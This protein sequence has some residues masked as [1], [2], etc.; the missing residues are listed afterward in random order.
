MKITKAQ[1]IKKLMEQQEFDEMAKKSKGVQA[2]RTSSDTGELKPAKFKPFWKEGNE[3]DIPD[4]WVV[5][6]DQIPGQGKI[7]VRTD[8]VDTAQFMVENE[9]WLNS[10]TEEHGLTPE[11]FSC[12]KTKDQPRSK[13]SGTEYVPTGEKYSEKESILRTF[14][15][16]VNDFAKN[17]NEHLIKC[18]LPPIM[19][20]ENRQFVDTYADVTNRRLDWESHDY[21]F[22]NTVV[23]FASAA[24]DLI[25]QGSTDVEIYRTHMPRQ[26]NPGSN[27]SALRKSEKMNNQYKYNPLTDVYKLP[28]R[29]YEV[30]DKDVAVCTTLH[31]TGHI[32]GGQQYVWEV[33]VTTEMGRKLKEEQRINS[34][35]YAADKNI[36]FRQ[37]VG[38]PEGIDYDNLPVGKNIINLVV[39]KDALKQC[40]D[41]VAEQILQID[42]KKELMSRIR[43]RQGDITRK[44][45]ESDINDIVRDIIYDIKK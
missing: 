35:K 10:I 7:V 34:G 38:L 3:T 28:K 8:C 14:N 27:W 45:N 9:E 39:V 29:G 2:P 24:K 17:V 36:V 22:Y 31:I 4:Y 15:P 23:D 41:N 42:P 19:T 13:K 5:N 20:F 43:I 1:V 21:D 12:K 30:D 40:F 37:A 25:A 6:L 32:Y 44:L 11:L 16:V 18:G 33:K 26:Y